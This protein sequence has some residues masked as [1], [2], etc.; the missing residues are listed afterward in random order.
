MA[1]DDDDEPDEGEV[2]DG[3]RVYED[4]SSESE[5]SDGTLITEEADG[6]TTLT[7]PDGTEA[8]L[9]HPPSRWEEFWLTFLHGR[10]VVYL[11]S[12]L[13]IAGLGIGIG[14]SGYGDSTVTA[15]RTTSIVRA[16][17]VPPAAPVKPAAPSPSPAILGGSLC[18]VGQGATSLINFKLFTSTADNEHVTGSLSSAGGPIAGSAQVTGGVGTIPFTITQFGSFPAVTVT[19]ADGTSIPLGPMSTLFPFTVSSDSQPCATAGATAPAPAASTAP[20]APVAPAQRQVTTVTTTTTTKTSTPAWS[21]LSAGGALALGGGLLLIGRR[22]TPEV[23]DQV[24][25]DRHNLEADNDGYWRQWM[26]GEYRRRCDPQRAAVATAQQ[27]FDAAKTA[28]DEA[29]Q[30][31]NQNESADR[32]LTPGID[33]AKEMSYQAVVDAATRQGA[34]RIDLEVA[35][36]RLADCL[37]GADAACSAYLTSLSPPEEDPPEVKVPTDTASPEYWNYYFSH[38]WEWGEL[39]DP[40]GP[41]PRPQPTPAVPSGDPPRTEIG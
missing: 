39:A 37:A 2:I 24:T 36:K 8:Y 41:D 25:I 11:S 10:R 26:S 30:L 9:P 17:P 16:I 32:A 21:W 40:T 4:G 34:A 1:P 31:N 7:F 38:H 27:R 28:L 35:E 23:V 22:K 6:S 20:A 13:I 18:V 29:E 5:Y 33:A 12:A 19:A 14:L 3:V 15:V